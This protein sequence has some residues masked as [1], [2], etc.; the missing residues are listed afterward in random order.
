MSNIEKMGIQHTDASVI[1]I[2]G[3][4]VITRS[5]DKEVKQ[6]CRGGD[7]NHKHKL[8]ID[9][10]IKPQDAFKGMKELISL[11]PEIGRLLVAQAISGI[12]R[13]VF[14][15]ARFTPCTI[16][17]IKGK[18][19]ML[20]SHY[21][22]HLTQLYDRGTDIRAATRF[23]SSNRFIEDLLCEYDECTVIIDDLHTA[24]SERIKRSNECTAEEIIR[25]VSDD[26]GRGHKEGNELVQKKFQGNVIFIGEYSIGKGSTNSRMLIAELTIRP[27]GTILDKYQRHKPLLVSTFYYYYI[28]WYV[29]NYKE[30]YNEIDKRITEFRETN[31][32]SHIYG[33]LLDAQLYLQTSYMIF[34]EFCRDSGFITQED[35]LD[36]FSYFRDQLISLILA[37]QTRS[38]QDESKPQE[39]NYLKLIRKLYKKG[40]FRLAD[41]AETFCKDKHDGL[42]YYEC[43]CVRRESLEKKLHKI[44]PDVKIDEVTK[45]LE[46]QNALKVVDKRTV[47]ISTL[48]KEAGAIRFCAIWLSKLK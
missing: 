44:L 31:T 26:T 15:R 17:F 1:Y 34:L 20:K 8:D 16:L 10:G 30:I 43:L 46:A 12:S 45:S 11:S 21:I 39:I 36:E 18:S 4:R 19:N 27:D 13:E 7:S 42:I 33:R 9:L 47:K 5:S 32:E 22:P 48:N 29:D 2:A 41:S 14:L 24:E 40:K 25:R 23:N 35:A 6:E 28:Q 3:D 38:E 37:Q